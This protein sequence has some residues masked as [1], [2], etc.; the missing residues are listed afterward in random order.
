MQGACQRSCAEQCQRTPPQF[1]WDLA[2]SRRCLQQ[3]AVA[4]AHL[5]ASAV[6]NVLQNLY[7]S[8]QAESLQGQALP[9][10][11]LGIEPTLAQRF[12]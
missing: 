8:L 11:G 9:A 3:L 4:Q 6:R 10:V 1:A 2:L 5:N 7:H 12:C